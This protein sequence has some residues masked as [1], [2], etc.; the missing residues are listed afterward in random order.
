MQERN[1]ATSISLGPAFLIHSF[2]SSFHIW[3][4]NI[5]SHSGAQTIVVAGQTN[6]NSEYL[7]DPIRDGLHVAR[8]K[9]G[10]TIYLLDHAI[11]IRV[12]KRIDTDPHVLAEF[13]QTQ[14]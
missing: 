12:R 7:F 8:S 11:E 2:D 4:I 6:L 13:D 14:P 10:L 5:C 1:R 9:F 3:K